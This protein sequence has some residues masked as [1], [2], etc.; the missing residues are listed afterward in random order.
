MK[1]RRWRHDRSSDGRF[2]SWV[3]SMNP[4]RCLGSKSND[5]TRDI[6]TS[7]NMADATRCRMRDRERHA[8]RWVPSRSGQRAYINIIHQKPSWRQPS[9]TDSS[10]KEEER[11][12][13][14]RE[15]EASASIRTAS[16]P[17]PHPAIRPGTSAGLPL[18]RRRA[19]GDGSG[20]W[21]ASLLP[22]LPI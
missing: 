20:F 8:V 18:L 2:D 14:K 4:A 12:R 19:P 5:V 16:A 22:L 6:V 11:W 1:C 13:R 10:K 21:E 3:V 15:G 7:A 17:S 9:S